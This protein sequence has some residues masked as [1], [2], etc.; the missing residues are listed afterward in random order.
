MNVI[1]PI[2]V[3]TACHVCCG[4]GNARQGD[5]PHALMWFAYG[6]ANTGL[7]WYELTK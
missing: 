7:L 3:C 5:Y 6:L 1:L 4:I 2:L